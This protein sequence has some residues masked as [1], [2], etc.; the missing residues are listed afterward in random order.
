MGKSG[1][2]VTNGEKGHTEM[3]WTYGG[4]ER[5]QLEQLVHRMATYRREK[6]KRTTKQ[7]MAAGYRK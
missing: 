6:I 2:I 3:G 4:N 1:E 7:N 5:Q